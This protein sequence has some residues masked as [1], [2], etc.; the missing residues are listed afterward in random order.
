MEYTVNE[1]KSQIY[2]ACLASY[3]NGCLSGE[4]ITP[5]DTEDKLQAQIDVILKA[6]PEPEAEEWAIHDYDNFPNL[7]EYPNLEDIIKVTEAQ[8]KHGASQ[9]NAFIKCYSVEDLEH[10]EESY[11]GEYDSFSEYSNELADECFDAREQQYFDY[12]AFE[13]DCHYDC[14]EADAPNYKVYIFRSF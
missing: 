2:V 3:N 8:K 7:G 10:F 5:E 1:D 13:R 12:D 11:A 14:H 6:S 4:W 9:I